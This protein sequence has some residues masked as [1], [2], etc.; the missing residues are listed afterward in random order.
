MKT[1]LFE[2]RWA[3]DKAKYNRDGVEY[4]TTCAGTLSLYHIHATQALGI[5]RQMETW[6]IYDKMELFCDGQPHR[7]KNINEVEGDKP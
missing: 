4:H 5:M 3:Y 7:I 1:H 2:I 6:G